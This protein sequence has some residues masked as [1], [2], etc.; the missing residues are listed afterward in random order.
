MKV[1]V[2]NLDRHPDRLAHMRGQL[3]DI[4]FARIAAID[5]AKQAPTTKGLTRFEL[6]CLASHRGAWRQFLD[7]VES[8]ACFFEDDL[9]VWPRLDELIGSE[10]WIPSDAHSIKLDT[11]FQRVKLGD[12]Q[13]APGGRHVARLFTRHESSAAYLLTRAGA[14]RYLE[15]TANPA[16]PADYSLF[17]RKSSQIGPACLSADARDRDPG[18]SSSAR[19]RRSEVR[20]RDG[21][22]RFGAAPPTVRARQAWSGGRAAHGARARRRGGNLPRGLPE[23]A[24]DDRLRRIAVT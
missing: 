13:P 11:Y 17:P 3:V 8:Y 7:G 16:L 23:A 9:H 1:Y 2:L 20:D 10:D 6:A 5:G 4:P 12:A 22:R 18:S 24:H 19:R 14:R 15:L 21:R